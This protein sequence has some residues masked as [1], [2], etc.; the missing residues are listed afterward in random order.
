LKT[1]W[2]T[3]GSSG[4]GLATAE[5]FLKE[6][7]CVIISSKN[8][9]N[10][11]QAKKQLKSNT[12]KNKIYSIQCDL[13]NRV[14]VQNVVNKIVNEI[15]Q[16][17]IGLLNA[18]AYSPNKTQEFDINNYELLIDVNLKGTLYCIETLKKVMEKN[19]GGQ[20]AIISSP[21]G[22]R[23]LPT[24]GAYG[25]TKAGLINLAESLFFDFKKF[26]IKI[27]LINPG[28]IKTKST[29][30]NSFPMPF[31]K[32]SSFAAEKIFNGLTKSNKFEIIFPYFFLKLLKLGRI[33]PY[34]IYFYL[35]SKITGL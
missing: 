12:K 2:I 23:G 8:L 33:L 25:M 21:V 13:S 22:Y 1:I 24:A 6:D 18:A 9:D 35:I 20:I 34:P 27:K 28:F 31:I 7:W 26:G 19:N 16:I 14:E 11:N 5:K 30:L 15:G 17:N 10:L 32:S 4:I 3:G 29:D